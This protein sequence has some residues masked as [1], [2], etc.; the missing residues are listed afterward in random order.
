MVYG[1]ADTARKLSGAPQASVTAGDVTIALDYATAMVNSETG[2]DTWIS[3]DPEWNQINAAANYWA[4]S[5]I[6]DRF[7][8]DKRISDE[9][10]RR[11]KDI[12]VMVVNNNTTG[13]S[14]AHI[15][16]S[17]NYRTFPAYSK[18]EIYRSGIGGIYSEE[19]LDVYLWR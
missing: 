14:A 7:A 15:V 12:C 5:L 2:K 3:T 4:A 8:D 11:A 19:Y 13:T 18:G 9:F 17:Q 6:R 16:R 10:Y 1:D